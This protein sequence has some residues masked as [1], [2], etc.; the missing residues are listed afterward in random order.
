MDIFTGD[1][2]GSPAIPVNGKAKFVSERLYRYTCGEG[3]DLRGDEFVE[4]NP[5][6][7]QWSA[8]PTCERVH[9]TEMENVTEEI[10]M[11]EKIMNEI[12]III[13]RE[14]A[15]A[16]ASGLKSWSHQ[17]HSM[18]MALCLFCLA[19]FLTGWSSRRFVSFVTIVAD[20]VLLLF[21][22]NVVL[23]DYNI[24][25]SYPTRPLSHRIFSFCASC[26]WYL[27]NIIRAQFSQF[28]KHS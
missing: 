9:S 24:L 10:A 1:D 25:C 22:I 14:E 8:V 16:G 28:L 3:F 17:L 6:T 20:P 5:S 4:C 21:F 12:E 27:G 13:K 7:R 18:W 11:N 2:C 26:T 23:Q 15:K 19:C